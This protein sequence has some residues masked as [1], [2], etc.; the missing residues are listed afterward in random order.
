E[1]LVVFSHT[2]GA[3]LMGLDRASLP[4]GDL[5]APYLHS[6]G[7]KAGALVQQC[8]GDL[9]PAD[10]VYGRGHCSLAA[11]R[12]FWDGARQQFVC[13]F[14]PGVPADDTLIV[15]RVTAA[16]GRMLATVVNYACH[17]T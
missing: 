13:G 12:D 8:L 2:H 4:G 6:L 9:A 15:A 17:P 16:D 3:G 14:N 7:V 5:I 1:V 10:I 11:H